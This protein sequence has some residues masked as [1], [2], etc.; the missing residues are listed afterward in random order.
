MSLP[1]DEIFH[2]ALS[3]APEQRAAFLAGACAADPAQ[4]A[5]VEA[6]LVNLDLAARFLPTGGIALVGLFAD[7]APRPLLQVAPAG[8]EAIPEDLRLL[9]AGGDQDFGRWSAFTS[10]TTISPA[11]SSNQPVPLTAI[12]SEPGVRRAGSVPP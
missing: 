11:F 5:R 6:L 2:D 3:R 8:P 10:A 9:A 12:S 4:R 7:N 1:D